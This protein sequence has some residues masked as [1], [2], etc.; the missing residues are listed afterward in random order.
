MKQTHLFFSALITLVICIYP[1]KAFSDALTVFAI[2]APHG[3][4]LTSPRHLAL[5][6][7]R[8]YSGGYIYPTGHAAFH[9]VCAPSRQNPGV[10]IFDGI[11]SVWVSEGE[12]LT[13]QRGYGLGVMFAVMSGH[14]EGREMTTSRVQM[15]LDSGA[16][17]FIRF[18][19]SGSACHRIA[20]FIAEYTNLGLPDSYGLSLRPRHRE[21]ANCAS[22][23][24]ALLEIGGLADPGLMDAWH[25]SLRVPDYLVGGPMN[26]RFIPAWWFLVRP[27]WARRWAD[28][29]EPHYYIEFD[30]PGRLYHHIRNRWLQGLSPVNNAEMPAQMLQNGSA[31]GFIVHAKSAPVP[32][33][34]FWLAPPLRP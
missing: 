23:V 25:V 27:F 21:G 18:E 8:N 4:D 6:A 13:R 2:P 24:A 33:E 20:A 32:E 15:H 16:A 3:N 34:R 26:G 9:L 7:K 29:H 28:A 12:N 1:D 22:F 31:H 30:D 5:S 19:I 14:F 17:S 10:D 11:N